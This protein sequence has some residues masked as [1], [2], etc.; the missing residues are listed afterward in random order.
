M[1]V[2]V[3]S[4]CLPAANI[5]FNLVWACK[6]K[7]W[8]KTSVCF[9]AG[10]I[11]L[12]SEFYPPILTVS[13]FAKRKTALAGFNNA[14]LSQGSPLG[15]KRYRKEVQASEPRAVTARCGHCPSKSP[16]ERTAISCC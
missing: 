11:S 5:L 2:G 10:S 1:T 9:T 15:G 12:H 7:R 8:T 13:T 16:P 3:W 4:C 14:F 6:D